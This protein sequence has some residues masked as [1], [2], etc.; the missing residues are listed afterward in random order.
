MTKLKPIKA[1]SKEVTDN[2]KSKFPSMSFRF[3]DNTLKKLS[4]L[5]ELLGK[6][7]A[8]IVRELIHAQY[9]QQVKLDKAAVSKVENKIK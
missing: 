3:G 9:D 4:V 5:S 8:A 7:K 1:L 2:N 6:K